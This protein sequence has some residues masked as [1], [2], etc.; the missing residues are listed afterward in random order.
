MTL[1]AGSDRSQQYRV[2]DGRLHAWDDDPPE[3]FGQLWIPVCGAC[4]RGPLVAGERFCGDC[5]EELVR[6]RAGIG[7]EAAKLRELCD[8]LS[9]QE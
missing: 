7:V 8:R 6:Q 4:R 9:G 5:R 2:I 1:R 3:E